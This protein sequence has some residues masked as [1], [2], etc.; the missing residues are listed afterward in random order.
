MKVSRRKNVRAGID[1]SPMLDVIFQLILFFLVSTT[2]AV[3]PGIKLNLPES[4]TSEN[5]EAS[6]VTISVE[7]DGTMFFNEE[8]I[9]EDQL[10]LKLKEVE[11]GPYTTETYPVSISADYNVKNGTLVKIFDVLRMNSFSA[12]SLRTTDKK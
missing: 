12:V 11:L 4:A 1:L 8:Q 9:T 5:T 6:G 2:F 3:L 10:S 7:E